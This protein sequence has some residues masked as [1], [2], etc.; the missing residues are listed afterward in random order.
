MSSWMHVTRC[1]LCIYMGVGVLVVISWITDTISVHVSFINSIHKEF[2]RKSMHAHTHTHTD[3]FIKC[4]VCLFCFVLLL[5]LLCVC[6]CV[7]AHIVTVI[8]I[9]VTGCWISV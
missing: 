3:S 9:L 7:R 5:L 1:V 6:V 4:F 2:I 8:K